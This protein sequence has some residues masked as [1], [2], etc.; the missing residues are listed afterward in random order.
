[1][2][3]AC[4]KDSTGIRDVERLDWSMGQNIPNPAASVTRIPYNVPQSGRIVFSVM[5][6]NGQLLH[7]EVI[8]AEGGRS[9]VE[10]QVEGYAN[11][12]YYYSMEYQGQRIVRKM[13]V[14]R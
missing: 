3:F 8:E 13:S 7:R 9:H 4:T 5:S 14:T 6:A 12:I 2:E 1:M 11:G 10:L